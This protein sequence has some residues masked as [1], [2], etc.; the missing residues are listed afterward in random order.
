MTVFNSGHCFTDRERSGPIQLTKIVRVVG[1]GDSTPDRCMK[2]YH[3]KVSV[4]PVRLLW[5]MA[6]P[7][8]HTGNRIRNF[9]CFIWSADS[10]EEGHEKI[11]APL[12]P[13]RWSQQVFSKRRR[14]TINTSS[15]L[16]SSCIL[17]WKPQWQTA[18]I[19]CW[20]AI[21]K[22]MG[23]AVETDCLEQCFS[24]FVR[25]RPGKFFFHKTRARSQQIYS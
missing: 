17:P 14:P 9:W 21:R 13:W 2:F 12:R 6:L 3:R 7:A 19:I 20:F 22:Q 1:N 16:E 8:L 24:I 10:Q 4:Y 18:D 15:R 5:K 25:P 23:S 11:F